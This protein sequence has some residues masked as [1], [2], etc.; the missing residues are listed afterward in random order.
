MMPMVSFSDLAS[1]I[2]RPM[3]SLARMA[4]RF[5]LMSMICWLPLQLLGQ[6][7]EVITDRDT[8]RLGELVRLK[9]SDGKITGMVEDDNW[10]MHQLEDGIL[11]IQGFE[12]GEFPLPDIKVTTSNGQVQVLSSPGYTVIQAPF[13]PQ[14]P[15]PPK[16]VQE[17]WEI[18]V[19]WQDWLPFILTVSGTLTYSLIWL[20]AVVRR[21]GP[22]KKTAPPPSPA[23]LAENTLNQLDADASADRR[24][25][26]IQKV[27]RL[28]LSDQFLVDVGG[29]NTE[30]LAQTGKKCLPESQELETIISLLGTHE[31]DRFAGNSISDTDVAA[32]ET[33]LRA[34]I[35]RSEELSAERIRVQEK[36]YGRRASGFRRILAG[37][38]DLLPLG[39]L[40]AGLG[41]WPGFLPA[42]GL[43]QN[44]ANPLQIFL[45]ALG[46]AILGRV[47][48]GFT[49]VGGAWR[50]TPG[51]RVF[52]LAVVSD[53]DQRQNNRLAFRPL[54]W[55]VATLPL[56]LGHA[57]L[58]L[59]QRTFPDRW[60]DSHI[61]YYPK[62]S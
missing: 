32:L 3:S 49:T 26:R 35:R 11:S 27:F 57:G 13:D 54:F 12:V 61:R 25:S 39:L 31:A 7:P 45:A 41:I 62:G 6:A 33:T 22:N 36:R 37:L 58:L 20:L 28:Y 52:R 51:M 50:A 2:F 10:Q 40:V 9:V 18:P 24:F 4:S 47:I 1:F 48:T 43:N 21:Y 19:S 8:A 38:A 5:M 17:L 46:L 53:D 29:M 16:G 34:L 56:W 15:P 14:N 60:S 59:N 42:I 23:K 44:L 30:E 55:L